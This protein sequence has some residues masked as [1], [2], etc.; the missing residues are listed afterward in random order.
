MDDDKILHIIEIARNTGKI[1]I[2]SNE[3]TNA[4]ERGIAKLVISAED[5]NPKEITMHLPPLCNEKKIPYVTVKS[6]QELGR[7][8]GIDVPA[9]A[10]AIIQEG[11]AKKDIEELLRK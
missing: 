9:A 6:K 3:T 5:V 2:G 11:D 10:I 7:A 1:K 8:A 4:F